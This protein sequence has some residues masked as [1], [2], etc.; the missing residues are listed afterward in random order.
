MPAISGFIQNVE[1]LHNAIVEASPEPGRRN[2]TL[3][4]NLRFNCFSDRAEA[5]ERL[6]NRFDT[7]LL[8]RLAC[9][10]DDEET[11]PLEAPPSFHPSESRPWLCLELHLTATPDEIQRG[12]VDKE[13]MAFCRMF[14]TLKQIMLRSPPAV[15]PGQS[16]SLK[17]QRLEKFKIV[18]PELNY[19]CVY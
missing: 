15:S 2:F 17:E 11:A 13:V 16:L 1:R 12:D 3:R 10:E 19:G 9:D 6:W 18:C 14:P 5:L 4:I 8:L 7:S